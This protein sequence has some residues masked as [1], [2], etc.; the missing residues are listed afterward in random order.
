MEGYPRYAMNLTIAGLKF[1]LA[2]MTKRRDD[3]MAVCELVLDDGFREADRLSWAAPLVA[4]LEAAI[5]NN[6]GGD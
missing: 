1:R 4:Q 2:Q 3:L 5:A 6:K